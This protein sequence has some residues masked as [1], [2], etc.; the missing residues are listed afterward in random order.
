MTTV[1]NICGMEALVELRAEFP[2]AKLIGM[3]PPFGTDEEF[4]P[5]VQSLGAHRTLA[6]PFKR[7]RLL[8]AVA[9]VLAA[10]G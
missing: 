9:A 3:L 5:I 7:E 1:S 2:Q 10:E 8:E 4:Q 6:K